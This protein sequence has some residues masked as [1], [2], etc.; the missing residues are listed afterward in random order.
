MKSALRTIVPPTVCGKKRKERVL[1]PLC[2]HHLHLRSTH[3]PDVSWQ[4]YAVN[5]SKFS[6]TTSAFTIP[7]R[8]LQRLFPEVVTTSI[9]TWYRAEPSRARHRL[10]SARAG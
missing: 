2:V 10:G 8:F 7:Q 6:W 1:S 9:Q 4:V 3:G 5:R